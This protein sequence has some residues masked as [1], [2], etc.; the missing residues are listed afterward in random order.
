MTDKSGYLAEKQLFSI[1]QR[2][3]TGTKLKA[4]FA[5]KDDHVPTLRAHHNNGTKCGCDRVT[6]LFRD[7][8]FQNMKKNTNYL[9]RASNCTMYVEKSSKE[10][11]GC[12]S[13][14]KKNSKA[15]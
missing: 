12:K 6:F 15:A 9:A 11:G 8:S 1:S 2:R 13:A 4:S 10:I 7:V 5:S 3:R 14:R